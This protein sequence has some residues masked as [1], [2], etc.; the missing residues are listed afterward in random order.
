MAEKHIA[1]RE[2]TWYAANVEPDYCRVGDSVIPFD[3][4][5]TL[6][7]EKALF[8]KTFFAR[9]QPVILAESIVA[10]VDG[11]A[12]RGVRSGVSQ[13]N[14]HV[15]I[16]EGSGTF[17]IE[18]RPTA[19][20]L[21]R[22]WMNCRVDGEGEPVSNG[23]LGRLYT[24]ELPPPKPGEDEANDS[25]ADELKDRGQTL[26]DNIE[27]N[28]E[29]L[30]KNPNGK[31]PEEAQALLEDAEQNLQ[32]ALDYDTEVMDAIREGRVGDEQMRDLM[33]QS[34]RTRN[35]AYTVRE[36]A[37]RQV[38][39]ANPGAAVARQVGAGF[40]PFTGLA[41]VKEDASAAMEQFSEGNILGALGPAAMA[42]IGGVTELPGF[43][44]LKG[45]ANAA[46]AGLDVVSG[47]KKTSRVAGAGK[48]GVVILRRR[49]PRHKV[50]CF[51]PYDTDTFK[52]LSE[53]DKRKYL[54]E[55]S[56]QLRRQQDAI[57]NLSVEDYLSAREAFSQSGRSAAARA[58]QNQTR[59]QLAKKIADGIE[60]T[61]LRR[62]VTLSEARA[63]A[64]RRATGVMSNLAAL[65]EPDSKAG[66][67]N[68]PGTSRLGR[69]DVNSHIGP[70]WGSD[71]SP[72]SKIGG[73]DGAANDAMRSGN[74][75]AKMNVQLE[76]CRGRGMK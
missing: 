65:H 72:T 60:E 47:A 76:V 58:A 8:A 42:L 50:A 45:G 53:A 74:G 69:S 57:N 3:I 11:N 56:R 9:G 28:R 39:H 43:K 41:E 31:S 38:L 12:G 32:D 16:F 44:A 49:L 27:E 55:Y 13:E 59:R 17:F 71:E 40:V 14:G 25:D 54:E 68:Q 7:H 4:A 2:A 51:H 26:D 15:W 37:I 61:L 34:L 18:G 1:N 5:R 70:S 19:R 24:R 75:K 30:E 48:D 10:G 35:T 46:E 22:C 73:M 21:D 63:E 23:T 64:R 6:D 52:N 33:D 20:H 29:W 66:G 36:E 62:G 67:A